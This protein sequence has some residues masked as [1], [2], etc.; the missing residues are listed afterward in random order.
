MLVVQCQCGKTLTVP[1]GSTARKGV[2]PNCGQMLSLPR[3]AARDLAPAHLVELTGHQGPVRATC[4]SPD[5]RLLASA[6]GSDSEGEEQASK[7]FAEIRLWDVEHQRAKIAVQGHHDAVLCMAFTPDSQVLITGSMDQTL[8]VWD[9]SRGMH[10]VVL[11]L[12]EHTLRGHAARISSVSVSPDG[13]YFVSGSDDGEIRLWNT[14]QWRCDGISHS[15]RVGICRLQHSA[16]GRFLAGVWRSK[17]ASII[18]DAKTQEEYLRLALLPEEDSEAYDLAFS[19]DASFL[20]VLSANGLRVWD[21]SSCQVALAMDASGM[22]TLA[23]S[24]DGRYLVA[25]GWELKTKYDVQIWDALTGEPLQRLNGQH[26]SLYCVCFSPT[27]D[28]LACAG[29]DL[30]VHLWRL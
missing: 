6:G 21:L 18:W 19:P 25:G 10:D 27:G 14:T 24:P 15:G 22:R 1:E 26:N 23:W 12:K 8:I 17:G 13:S 29:R 9:V 5:G 16:D 2:C 3:T 30:A 4:F 11:G 7:P 20:A 28:E